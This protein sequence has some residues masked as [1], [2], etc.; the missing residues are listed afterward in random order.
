MPLNYHDQIHLLK[1]ILADHQI[2]CCGSVAEY[3]Q[4]ERVVKSLMVNNHIDQN[5]K[6]ILQD[7]Y[8]Y[9]QAGI[10]SANDHEVNQQHQAQFSNWIESMDQY[11]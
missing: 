11:S 1:D 5:V 10:N 4:L 9:S 3:E 7:I 2:D 6:N 8:T